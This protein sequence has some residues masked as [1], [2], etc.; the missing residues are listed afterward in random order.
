MPHS[1]REQASR[2]NEIFKALQLYGVDWGDSFLENCLLVTEVRMLSEHLGFFFPNYTSIDVVIKTI[3]EHAHRTK[4]IK[5]QTKGTVKK[6]HVKLKS[7]KDIVLNIDFHTSFDE[8]LD[9]V[10]DNYMKNGVTD[11]TGN[12]F[13]ATEIEHIEIL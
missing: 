10:L 8:A 2:F 5:Q 6:I 1:S 9:T 4:P 3:L 12:S 13:L 11:E 7:G